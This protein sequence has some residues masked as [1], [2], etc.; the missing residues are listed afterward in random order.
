MGKITC[1]KTRKMP[2]Y[3]IL[4]VFVFAV[5]EYEGRRNVIQY[6]VSATQIIMFQIVDQQR[7]NVMI[8]IPYLVVGIMSM[9][10]KIL[11]IFWIVNQQSQEGMCQTFLGRNPLSRIE[12]QHRD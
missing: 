11:K 9:R 4:F 7:R 12:R 2:S 1:D 6:S 5:M 3:F 10:L 8:L